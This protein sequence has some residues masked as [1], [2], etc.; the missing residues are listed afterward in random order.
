VPSVSAHV[1]ARLRPAQ[2]REDARRG[3][4]ARVRRVRPHFPAQGQP[5]RAPARAP[6]PQAVPVLGVPQVV[7]QVRGKSVV[8]F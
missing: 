5:G 4:V 8:F 6:G 1:P 3:A 2:P 7:Q